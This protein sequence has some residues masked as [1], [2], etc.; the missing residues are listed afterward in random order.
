VSC[1]PGCVPASAECRVLET[2]PFR[3]TR[4]SRSV[5]TPVGF[6]FQSRICTRPA[7][8]P[9]MMSRYRRG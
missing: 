4:L 6:T 3:T 8:G 2:Q 5:P 7:V 1:V 9:I